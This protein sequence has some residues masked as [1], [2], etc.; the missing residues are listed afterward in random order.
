MLMCLLV[1]DALRETIRETCIAIEC[2]NDGAAE[3]ETV[4]RPV[5]RDRHFS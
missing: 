3:G 2:S 4:G 1:M 5:Q